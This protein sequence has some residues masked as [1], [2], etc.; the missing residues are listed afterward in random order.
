MLI[1]FWDEKGVLLQKWCPERTT[2]NSEF[3]ISILQDLRE[4]IKNNRI[5]MLTRGVQLLH[6]NARPHTSQ[7]ILNAIQQ[8]NIQILPHP[9]YSPDLSPCDYWLFGP[10]K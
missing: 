6:D 2:I 10:M 7:L 9:P 3:Y 8:M 4:S 1:I 5:G